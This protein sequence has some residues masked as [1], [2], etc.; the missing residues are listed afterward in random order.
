LCCEGH[1]PDV[2]LPLFECFVQEAKILE[3]RH[4]IINRL[5]YEASASNRYATFFYGQY[6]PI[7]GSFDYVNAGHNPPMLF[8]ATD[9][10]GQVI[11]LEPG[12][13][14]VGLLEDAHSQQGSVRLSPFC[15]YSLPGLRVDR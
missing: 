2:I 6:D 4:E 12:G 5:V 14:V 13:T 15:A 9:K 11:R 3:F 10:G 1:F 7:H 8:R